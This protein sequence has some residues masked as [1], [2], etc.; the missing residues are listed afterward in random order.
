MKGI[1]WVYFILLL[2]VLGSIWWGNAHIAKLS[3]ITAEFNTKQLESDQAQLLLLEQILEV[4]TE[5]KM[6][7]DEIT[8]T[9]GS[10]P[11]YGRKKVVT[12]VLKDGETEADLKTRHDA[13]VADAKADAAAEVA[14]GT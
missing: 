9:V 4:L 1:A 12:T 13:R 6:L 11:A 7:T 5:K 14:A 10:N 3:D 8:Y 2:F